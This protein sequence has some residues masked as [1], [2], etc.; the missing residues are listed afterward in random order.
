MTAKMT[1]M[2]SRLLSTH[3]LKRIWACKRMMA[4]NRE[5]LR[6]ITCENEAPTGKMILLKRMPMMSFLGGWRRLLWL[7]R[8]RECGRPVFCASLLEIG[9]LLVLFLVWGGL[10]SLFG[11]PGGVRGIPFFGGQALRFPF[12]AVLEFLAFLFSKELLAFLSFFFPSFPWIFGSSPRIKNPCFLVG[13]LCCFPK[14]QGKED[15]GGLSFPG[16]GCPKRKISPKFH[17]RNGK[18]NISL[19]CGVALIL[20]CS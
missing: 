7:F 19:C 13:F 2:I 4:M 3:C 15:Q 8:R 12:L 17:A 18:K 16:F 14:K 1:K 5:M 6:R 11:R 20:S 9:A 10:G